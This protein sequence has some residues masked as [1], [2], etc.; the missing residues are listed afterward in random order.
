MNRFPHGFHDPEAAA[1][2]P[3]RRWR[4]R[5][6][7]LLCGASIAALAACASPDRMAI[8]DFAVGL[9]A[10]SVGMLEAYAD[11]NRFVVEEENINE[12]RIFALNEKLGPDGKPFVNLATPDPVVPKEIIASRKAAL[13]FLRVYARLLVELSDGG[14]SESFSAEIGGFG[15]DL[16]A[17]QATLR[18][19]GAPEKIAGFDFAPIV[20]ALEI[21]GTKLIE[22]KAARAISEVST[23]MQPEIEAIFAG[24]GRDVDRLAQI[25]DGR[26][27]NNEA[28][29]ETVLVE[30]K[31]AEPTARFALYRRYSALYAERLAADRGLDQLDRA[32]SALPAAHAAITEPERDDARTAIATFLRFADLAA[33]FY[34]SNFEEN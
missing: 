12:A 28:S 5:A 17:L 29:Y 15:E 16:K 6:R 4:R 19:A 9:D 32:I 14:L 21:A 2:P 10:A 8:G 13:D 3:G 18:G 31:T 23:A 24:L 11:T 25:Y 7:V 20:T 1:P 22:A 34:A 30:T 33:D 26:A 27:K